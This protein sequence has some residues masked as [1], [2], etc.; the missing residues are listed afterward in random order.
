MISYPFFKPRALV[1]PD[2][3]TP[4]SHDYLPSLLRDTTGS[5][6]LQ[7]ILLFSPPVIFNALWSTYFIGK[8][9]KLAG[10]PIGNYVVS[11]G[12]KRLEVDGLR[13]V[14]KE[15]E[16]VGVSGLIRWYSFG[17]FFVTPEGR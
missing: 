8:V 17:V 10:H 1:Q 16:A 14:M 11:S 3:P 9:G 5:H 13:A 6:L 2:P 12:I 15:L 4:T 7:T